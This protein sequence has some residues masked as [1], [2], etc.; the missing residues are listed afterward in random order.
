MPLPE[1]LRLFVAIPLPD[2]VKDQLEDAQA[3]LRRAVSNAKVRWATRDQFHLTLKFLGGIPSP[4][5]HGLADTIRR[6]GVQFAPIELSARTV[7]FFPGAR[8]PRVLWVGLS[9][10]AK[11][12]P[13]LHAA[14][15]QSVAPFTTE[16]PEDRFA[17][18]VTLGRIKEIRQADIGS[19]TRVASGMAERAFGN[20]TA[21]DVLLMRSFLSPK[22]ARYEAIATAP[23]GGEQ[24]SDR[25]EPLDASDR[26]DSSL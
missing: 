2:E 26:P 24:P 7:G 3:E 17:A 20:W 14:L 22:G 25:S 16:A 8:S 12:L 18:H 15:E 11:A 1:T 6:V 10:A 5:V 23:L 19:L 21:R 9:D 4:E 13:M